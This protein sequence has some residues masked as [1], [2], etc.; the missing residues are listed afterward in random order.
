MNC[1]FADAFFFLALLNEGDEAHG[2]AALLIDQFDYLTTTAW[3][4]TEVADGCAKPG[5]RR[6]T[7]TDFLTF[8][9]AH[10]RVTIVPPDQTLFD[11]GLALYR[12]RPDKEWSLTDCISFVVMRNRGLTEALTEDHH[13][14]QAGFVA[15]MRQP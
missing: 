13:F 10:E 6:A 1:W 5:H 9:L 7:F 8:L 4:L 12:K 3:V 2:R 11:R 14:E 15:L